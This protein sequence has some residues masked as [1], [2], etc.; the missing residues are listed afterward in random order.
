MPTTRQL[1]ITLLLILAFALMLLLQGANRLRLARRARV[2]VPTRVSRT[3]PSQALQPEWIKQVG[4]YQLVKW[5]R[6]PGDPREPAET[7]IIRDGQSREVTRIRHYYLH[8][9]EISDLTNDGWPEVVIMAAE[10]GAHGPAFYY[11]YSLGPR[12]SCLLAYAKGNYDDG[13]D[14]PDFHPKDL[15]GDGCKE[16]VT[17]YDGFAYWSEGDDDWL[18]SYAGA[19]RVPVV[20][21]FRHGRYVDMTPRYRRW[22]GG[23][24]AQARRQLLE[25]LEQADGAKLRGDSSQSLIEY[26]AIA[27]MMYGTAAARRLMR[28]ILTGEDWAAWVKFHRRIERVVAARYRRYAYPPVCGKARVHGRGAP[29]E[30]PTASALLYPWSSGMAK[31]PW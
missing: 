14:A 15:D 27:V 30:A 12:P 29:S 2:V 28:D 24:L 26:Y 23:K 3:P 13:P 7:I 21:G 5:S 4:D 8:I 18:A 17:W 10:P 19:A 1:P 25:A 6:P 31:A 9:D 20:F 16:I 11:V 22:L